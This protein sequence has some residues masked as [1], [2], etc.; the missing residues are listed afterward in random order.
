V[1]YPR[2]LREK[3]RSLRREKQLAIDQ[4]AERLAL[5]RST[6]YYWLR[7]LPLEAR[8][9]PQ[10]LAQ[11]R[12]SRSNRQRFQRQ[13][14]EAYELGRWEFPRLRAQP[15][16]SE[17]VAL[18]IAE[19]YK[20]NRNTVSLANS[21]PSVVILANGWIRYFSRNPVRYSV[22]IHADQAPTSI[23]A[24]WAGALGVSAAEVKFIMKSNSGHLRSRTWRCPYGVISVRACDTLFRAR[25]A[26][27]IDRLKEDWL[28]SPVI[29][30]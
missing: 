14:D 3:A 29:G 4:V 26:G 10:K 12:A 7:D 8:T 13:R 30:A 22:Q 16:F 1:A 11:R 15:T 23:A 9:R 24:F 17:F 20:R 25:L 28:H 2:Y 19:G 27:W 6:V 5:S 21:D 18:Y